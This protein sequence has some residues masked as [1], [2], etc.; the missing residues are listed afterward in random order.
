MLLPVLAFPKPTILP[1]PV[2]VVENHADSV[3]VLGAGIAGRAG[4]VAV[5]VVAA[6]P[7]VVPLKFDAVSVS[8]RI[9]PVAPPLTPELIERSSKPA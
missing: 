4:A 8:F 7:L 3:N 2:L 6:N 1:P 5:L 9:A